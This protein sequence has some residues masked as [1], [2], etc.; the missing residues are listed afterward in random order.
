MSA[1]TTGVRRSD[2]RA[3]WLVLVGIA[4]VQVGA[5]IA[6]GLFDDISPS[7]M[8]W[9]RVTTSAIVLMALVRPRLGLAP[10]S[11]GAEGHPCRTRVDWLTAIGFGLVLAGMNWAIYESFARIPLGLAVTIEFVGP[12]AVAFVG[13][14]RGRDVVW[15][16]LAALGVGLLGLRPASLDPLGVGFAVAAGACWAAY[17]LL[18]AKVGA[19]WQGL[20]GLAIASTVAAVA[21]LAPAVLS[22]GAGLL[23]P[24]ILALGAAV[25]LLSSVVP[26]SLEM[27]VLRR[28]PP[29]TFGILMS[30][31]PA[32]AALAAWV[33]LG[34]V[35]G[36]TEWAA[37]ACVVIASI[38]ATRAARGGAPMAVAP[39]PD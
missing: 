1:T 9:L 13:F 12:L 31:E 37:M 26:Y 4:S 18:S 15:V 24:R 34:E 19:R 29:A 21:M 28:L 6:K 14:R 7:G 35:L 33:V 10:G 3:V 36:L 16:L 11:S 5:A 23:E 38:G 27:M 20:D 2:A 39:A 32:A 17:I 22:D 30:L 25:G 8:V